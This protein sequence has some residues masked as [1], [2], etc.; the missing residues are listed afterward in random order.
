[1]ET[2]T[3]RF[4]GDSGAVRGIS[5]MVCGRAQNQT[6]VEKVIPA[7]GRR[8]PMRGNMSM[9]AVIV[10]LTNRPRN[11]GRALTNASFQSRVKDLTVG[12]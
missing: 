2:S 3:G 9:L 11:W 1:M 12:G 10:R 6:F 5:V 8:V 7:L 4:R